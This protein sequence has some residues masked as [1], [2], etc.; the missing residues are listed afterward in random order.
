[1]GSLFSRPKPQAL[2]KEVT[3]TLTAKEEQV[4]ADE[5]EESQGQK[6]ECHR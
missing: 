5:A 4:Q 3:D 1:M 2:P 6:V